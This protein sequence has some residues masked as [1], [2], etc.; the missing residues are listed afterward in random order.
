MTSVGSLRNSHKDKDD[1][2]EPYTVPITINDTDHI[3]FIDTGAS[4]TFLDARLASSLG[5]KYAAQQ[6]VIVAADPSIN[7]SRIGLS[8]PVTLRCGV[9]ESKHR[10]ELANLWGK[11]QVIIG[12]DLIAE[13]QLDVFGLPHSFSNDDLAT[14][15]EEE[16]RA[17][18][19][20]IEQADEVTP[21]SKRSQEDIRARVKPYLETNRLVSTASYCP[22]PESEIYLE[23]PPGKVVY[24][25]QY[26]IARKIAERMDE[27][28]QKWKDD[29]VIE[30]APVDTVF[31]TPVF[32]I[33]KKDAEGNKTKCRLCMDFR[34]LNELLHDD[35]FPLPRISNIFESLSGAKI[36]SV[37]DLQSA[38][39]RFIIHSEH[40]HKTA[41]T[42]RGIQYVFVR[43]PFGLKTLPSKFQRVMQHIIGDLDYAKAYMDD[44]VVASNNPQQHAEHVTTVIERL[45]QNNLK[46]NVDKCHIAHLHISLL[47]FTI[48]PQG[49]FIYS[50]KLANIDEWKAPKT[51]KQLQHYLGFVNYF[52]DHIP[53]ISKLTAPLDAIRA[54]SSLAR[55]WKEEHQQAFDKFKQLLPLCPP[56]GFPDQEVPFCI[57]TDA[58]NVGI[59]A[60]LYQ[61]CPKSKRRRYI[62][63]QARSLT[64]SERN[65]SAT[66]RELLA[67]VYALKKFHYYIWGTR[68]TLYTDHTALAYLHTQKQLNPMLVGWYETLADY[69][70]I[71]H[72]RPGIK[73]ILP[74]H[75]SRFFENT[76]VEGGEARAKPSQPTLR[77]TSTL[78]TVD[79]ERERQQLLETQH[80][81]GH[82][83][84]N[85]IVEALHAQ[86]VTWP[87]LK[88]DAL[89]HVQHCVPCLRYNPGPKAYHPL[90]PLTAAQ[91]FDHV[92]VDL[93]GP[94]HTSNSG[95]H[96]LHVLIDVHTR[97]VLLHA[98]PD[99]T[100][101]TISQLWLNIF[102]TF[103]FPKVV[104]SDNGTEFVNDHVRELTKNA[105]ID[106]RL[107]TPYHPRANGIA[108]RSVQTA[109]RMLFKLFNGIKHEWDIFVP[110][111]QYCMNLKITTVHKHTPFHVM[112]GRQS[113]AFQDYSATEIPGEFQP[114]EKEHE[115]T[116]NELEKRVGA[117]REMFHQVAHAGASIA[118]KR[119]TKFDAKVQQANILVGS[120]VMARADIRRS[121]SDPLNDG[122]FLVATNNKSGT[123]T[124]QDLEGKL[125]PRNYTP[126][127]LV[128]LSTSPQ[129][130]QE[131]YE[132]ERILDHRK[133][134]NRTEYLVRWA[135]YDSEDDSWEPYDNFDDIEVI[136]K[137][138]DVRN[139]S[140]KRRRC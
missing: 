22:L 34:Q 54:Q 68:F 23:T 121:K 66:K 115:H 77:L 56:L 46:L 89:K 105:G 26:P 108:E 59:G 33:P 20:T 27:E 67:I 63:F 64:K 94:F 41:F 117:M 47:G 61:T 133:I 126:S 24:R 87:K 92:A 83:G 80:L 4:H 99:K 111:V 53:M 6:G 112:F 69:N 1:S 32:P 136:H 11:A 51:V 101:Q 113:N 50:T 60:V 57:A 18:W 97:F 14:V 52:R 138:W 119:K 10:C 106:H 74:D 5:I 76:P 85:A 139:A 116:M 135:G 43:A 48:S 13:M 30:R 78:R 44:I 49:K 8:E 103:G 125:L 140:T 88:E 25:R 137:Y 19:I 134:N 38:F 84:A 107:V 40:R 130:A 62:S 129:F 118:K 132:V 109:K 110:F 70:F 104:Q 86:G 128:P 15:A 72:H 35:A 39:H 79:N 82:F 95:K 131:S 55:L 123:F 65:Y 122:P 124:L 127:Q 28:I 3:A 71:I 29:G 17:P 73:N 12:R 37:L 31:N 42:W 45:T 58:S 21:E 120:Y 98:I 16:E 100:K 7:M 102:T 81:M 36:F 96:Y 90:R 2:V 93:A 75:L 114:S 9:L 91:P